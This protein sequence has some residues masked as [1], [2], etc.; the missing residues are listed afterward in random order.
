MKCSIC[1]VVKADEDFGLVAPDNKVMWTICN[2]CMDR[3]MQNSQ[4]APDG[5][6]IFIYV[7][8]EMDGAIRYVGQTHDP[9]T[10]LKQHLAESRPTNARNNNKRKAAW[11]QSLLSV[12]QKPQMLI[13]EVT[14][15]EQRDEREQ[16]WIKKL[17]STC[18]LLNGEH[19]HSRNSRGPQSPDGSFYSRM[20]TFIVSDEQRVAIDA[21]RGRVSLA[22]FVRD[23]VGAAVEAAGAEWAEDPRVGGKRPSK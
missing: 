13:L 3:S 17:S 19:T 21:A 16:Y 6:T 14:T 10:R 23:A 7:L 11:I 1:E 15:L 20:F 2:S 22:Q 12:G 8:T 4:I 18:H 5:K 9:S